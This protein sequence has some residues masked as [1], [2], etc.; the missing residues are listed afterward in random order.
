[1][2]RLAPLVFVDEQAEEEG[3]AERLALIG[4]VQQP[5]LSREVDQLARRAPA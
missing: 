4:V 1:M 5:H 3:G 2:L